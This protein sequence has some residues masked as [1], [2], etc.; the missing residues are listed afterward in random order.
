LFRDLKTE[1][2]AEHSRSGAMQLLD[3]GLAKE[4]KATDKVD[5]DQYRLTGLTGTLRIMSPEVIQCMP[6]GLSADVYSF[7]VVT[8]EVFTG[9]RNLLTALEVSEGQRPECPVAG[10]PASLESNLLQP[11]WRERPDQRPSA[12]QIC[13]ELSSQLLNGIQTDDDPSNIIDR[14][15]LLRQLSMENIENFGRPLLKD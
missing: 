5:N 11:C 8:W 3:F 14:V 6:Y 2:V 4:L 13:E 10:M 1:N 12:T 9:D 7:A 15:E